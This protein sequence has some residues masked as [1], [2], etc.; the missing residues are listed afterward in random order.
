MKMYVYV[1]IY[2]YFSIRTYTC[3]GMALALFLFLSR[4]FTALGDKPF[5]WTILAHSSQQHV[6]KKGN[7]FVP[8]PMWSPCRLRYVYGALVHVTGGEHW[9]LF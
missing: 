1:S 9:L 3:Q 5:V 8:P 6:G 7:N 4:S 2:M